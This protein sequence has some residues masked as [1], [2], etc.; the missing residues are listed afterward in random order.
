MRFARQQSDAYTRFEKASHFML[1]LYL[2][3]PFRR[4]IQPLEHEID[5]QFNITF[6]ILEPLSDVIDRLSLPRI[7]YASRTHSQLAQ[8]V[9][10]VNKTHYK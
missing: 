7:L 9:R 1:L 3:D 4:I 5:L 8:V 6:L 10:E 2:T